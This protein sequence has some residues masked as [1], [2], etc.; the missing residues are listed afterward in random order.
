MKSVNR[1]Y[2]EQIMYSLVF[3]NRNVQRGKIRQS[4][5]AGVRDSSGNQE[6]SSTDKGLSFLEN[7]AA[8]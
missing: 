8:G 4:E 3:A 5:L 7:G 1:T 2:T 6:N